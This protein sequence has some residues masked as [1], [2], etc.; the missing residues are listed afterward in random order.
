MFT[1]ISFALGLFATLASHFAL[2][3]WCSAIALT[4]TETIGSRPYEIIWAN[5]TEDMHTPL[6]DFEKT[7]DDW[8]VDTTDAVASFARSREQ[9]IW[10]EAVGKLIYRREGNQ[11]IVT[12]RPPAP[13][14]IPQ[15]FDCVSLWIYGN[16]WAWAPVSSTPPVSVS[17]LLKNKDGQEI[18]VPMT[19]VQWQEWWFVRKKL[20][21]EMRKQ[22]ADGATFSGI[23]VINGRNLEDRVL[24]FDNI[25][26]YQESLPPLS[27][28][29][30]KKRNLTLPEGQT[31]G[32]NTG[33]GVLP[34]PTRE[35]TILPTNLTEDY[36]VT[37]QREVNADAGVDNVA[38]YTFCYTGDDGTLRYTYT[39]KT[40]RLD[41]VTASWEG[42]SKPFQPLLDGGVKFLNQKGE[43]VEVEKYSLVRCDLEKEVLTVVWETEWDGQKAQVEY[44][45][46]LWGKS[47]VVDVQCKDGRVARFDIGHVENVENPRLIQVPYLAG[48]YD[49]RPN[50]LALGPV[51]KPLFLLPILDHCR[52]N[53]SAFWFKNETSEVQEAGKKIVF[54]NGGAD[55]LPKTDGTRNPCFE[56]LFLTVSPE[57]EEVLPNI[58]NEP[59]PW[60]QVTGTRVWNAHGA[61]DRTQDYA[62]WKEVARYGM[63]QVVVTD[64]ETGWRDGGESFTFRTKAAPGR[65]GDE[66][67]REYAKK[68]IDLGFRYGIYNNYTDF[69]P[70]NEFWHEDMVTRDSSGNLRTAWA[71]CYN[72]KPSRAVEYESRLAPIIQEKF[73]LNT[74]Y[75][76]VHTAVMPWMYVDFDARVPGAATFAST[77]YAYG[78]IML[79]QKQT[80]NGPVYS[81]GNNHWYYVGLTDGNYGQD[82]VARLVTSPWLVDFDLR[83]MHP[84]GTSFGMGNLGMFYPQGYPL[85]ESPE[86]WERNLDQFLAAT[87]AFGHTG[88][89]VQEGGIQSAVRSYFCLQAL[90]S[91]Y[92]LDTIK[93]I[94]YADADGKLLETSEAIASE[95]FKRRQIA[96][97]YA[98]GLEV[99]VNGNPEETWNV[100]DKELPPFGWLVHDPVKKELVAESVLRDSHRCDY[101][102]SPDYIYADGRGKFTRFP[103]LICDGKLIARKLQDGNIELIPVKPDDGGCTM[104][105][106]ALDGRDASAVALD[107]HGK[108]LGPVETR[109]SRGYVH[110]V[111]VKGVF[112]YRITPGKKAETV[113]QADREV[114]VPGETVKVSG[115]QTHELVIPGDAKPFMSFW[116]KFEDAWIDFFVLPM[117]DVD[118]KLEGDRGDTLVLTLRSHF[119]KPTDVTVQLGGATQSGVLSP[120]ELSRFTFAVK[121]VDTVASDI[122]HVSK[123]SLQVQTKEASLT[124]DYWLKIANQQVEVVKLSQGFKHG[125]RLRG[126]SHD[127]MNTGDIRPT[128]MRCN[129]TVRSGFFMHPPYQQGVGSAFVIL[130]PIRLPESPQATLKAFAG[131]GDGSD[132][133]D[134]IYFSMIAIEENGQETVLAET[135]VKRCCWVPLEADLSRFAGKTIQFK[136]IADV[137]PNNDSSGDWANW[138]DLRIESTTPVLVTTLHD[139]PTRLEYETTEHYVP[140]L[141]AEQLRIAKEAT[142]HVEGI[143]IDS[144]GQFVSTV[145]LNGVPLGKLPGCGGD[146]RNGVFQTVSIP[147]SRE[148]IEKLSTTNLFLIDNPGGDCFKLRNVFL[149]VTLADGRHVT[150]KLTTPTYSQPHNWKYAEGIG[151]GADEKIQIEVRF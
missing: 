20:S 13:I 109:L 55:Y 79:H 36:K 80:W 112:S 58:P 41:D 78:E 148:A 92:A 70:V 113:L 66:S 14:T 10:G 47:L 122:E 133:G 38:S 31:V 151:V 121:E 123:V 132:L 93:D 62:I 73:N 68:M 29:P 50:V 101:V 97:Y 131:K 51:E 18:E 134:G 146:E 118:L 67:Q 83:K 39:P 137:G 35:E 138:G 63:T 95:A 15:P 60:M 32:T 145:Q 61:S 75:C 37:V 116:E 2:G 127:R 27:F 89:L 40:G 85:H 149:D 65:G 7:L 110:I 12:V 87:L 100:L 25:A 3:T 5:R 64:H 96:L 130:D 56:R 69:A 144:A 9:Q 114:A 49:S 30:R 26:F 142:L 129:D 150:S 21:P 16:N 17:I 136:L 84:L 82:Q 143:G 111:P 46:R 115:K 104:F 90:H 102:E 11:P 4:D 48:N 124:K 57:F 59:S 52:S 139:E 72:P 107:Y 125:T 128:T 99:Y 91:R 54:C 119:A 98:D 117:A 88:F 33:P 71:R 43:T 105:A 141:Q 19:T 76:D 45:F 6:V 81:E 108:E 23:R 22:L 86:A 24:Y 28:E 74:A 53:A 77:F 135:A 94:R 106:I 8:Q 1:R 42:R 120:E 34:F 103:K 140:G 126:E 44:R 147:L